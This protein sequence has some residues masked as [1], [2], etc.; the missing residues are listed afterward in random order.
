M[1]SAWFAAINA[2]VADQVRKYPKS[3]ARVQLA[4]MENVGGFNSASGN[5][6]VW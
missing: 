5:E 4:R 6:I 1:G 3:C 2:R